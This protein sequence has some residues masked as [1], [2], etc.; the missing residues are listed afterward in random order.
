MAGD[1]AKRYFVITHRSTPADTPKEYA[2]LLVLPGGS[3]SAEFLPFCANV[4]TAVGT[5]KDFIVAELVA[6]V[7]GKLDESSV[8]WPGKAFPNKEARFTSEEFVAAV[9]A[10]VSKVYSIHPGW[11]F[12]LGW[13]SSGHVLYSCSFENPQIRGSFIAMSRFQPAYF[14]HSEQAKDKRYYLWHSPDDTICPYADAELAASYLAR[15]GASALLK[16]YKGGHGWVPFTFYADR[17][18]EALEWFR[19]DATVAPK[20]EEEIDKKASR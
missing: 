3:G 6:P 19:A 8:V 17:I 16:S 11:V 20:M 10:D 13:S 7:W 1:A 15:M 2:L 4:L 9:I 12:T 18:K 14:E 5:P